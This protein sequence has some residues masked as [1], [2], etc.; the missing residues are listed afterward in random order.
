MK[1]ASIVLYLHG[2]LIR[3]DPL[4]N[5]PDRISELGSS[6][7]KNH[8]SVLVA[9]EDDCCCILTFKNSSNSAI[10]PGTIS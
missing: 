6:F 3:F 5:D 8:N 10:S 4:M 2:S 9:D 7:K 1:F